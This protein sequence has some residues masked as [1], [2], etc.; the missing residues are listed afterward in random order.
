MAD[1]FVAVADRKLSDINI[2][3]YDNAAVC[4]V[5]ASGGYPAEYE[6]GKEITGIEEAEK[7]GLMV[8]HAGTEEKNGKVLTKGGRVLNVTA[9]GDSIEGAIKNVYDNIE[10]ISFDKMFFRKDIA[11]RAINRK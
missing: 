2:E 8:F 7:A 5:L 6:N 3:W 11:H 10:K 4:V 1:I 9:V